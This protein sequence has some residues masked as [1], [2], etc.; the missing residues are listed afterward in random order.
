M[1][2]DV[3]QAVLDDPV[4]KPQQAKDV[5]WLSHDNAT[6]TLARCLPSIL[7]SLEREAQERGDAQAMGLSVFMQSYKF[8][9]T[10]MMMRDIL[11]HLSSLSKAMQVNNQFK[12]KIMSKVKMHIALKG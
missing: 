4:L 3:F 11:P 5:R 8:I 12:K 7:A 9:A 1:Y 2:N 10:L 6:R